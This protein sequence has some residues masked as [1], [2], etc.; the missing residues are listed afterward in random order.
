MRRR[1]AT[2]AGEIARSWPSLTDHSVDHLDAL[3]EV[4]DLLVAPSDLT[5][6]EVFLLG[7]AF[8]THDLANGAAA[9]PDGSATLRGDPR[10]QDYV[11][12]ALHRHLGREPDASER[13]TPPDKVLQEVTATL[14]R[15]RH[16]EKAAQLPL[17]PWKLREGEYFLID[18][19]ELRSW[20]G[21]IIGQIARS[22][23]RSIRNVAQDLAGPSRSAP[24]NLPRGWTYDPL[25]IAA[26]LRVADAA[27]VDDRR[28]RPFPMAIRRPEG[29]SIPHWEFQSRTHGPTVDG[30]QLLVYSASPAF[31]PD[32]A[33]A[34]WLAWETLQMVDGEVRQTNAMLADLNRPQLAARGVYGAEDPERFRARFPAEGWVPVNVRIRSSDIV[35]LAEKLGGR[36][37]YGDHPAVP[38][39]ELI[40]NASDAIRARR[41]VRVND[42]EWRG[43]ITV[44]IGEDERGHW[45]EVQDNGLGMF[46]HVLTG[47]LLDFGTSYWASTTMIEDYPGLRASAFKATGRY[48]IG[49]FSV[50]MWSSRFGSRHALAAR[51]TGPGYWSFPL[52]SVLDRLYTTGAAQS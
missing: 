25:R 39:R 35:S 11:L 42:E 14:L 47:P 23:G 3:W 33:E 1:A 46:D 26:I 8:L 34:W 22:H 7:G 18:D 28:A 51:D 37:L 19:T 41:F 29:D 6:L 27:Q 12:H 50:F 36:H 49:F 5:P 43:R 44:R 31:T 10:W 13:V 38:L 15:I 20:L 48:G 30:Q 52:E 16:S 4:A 45:L 9:Y 2:I 24:S 32:V 17:E 40:Q 21:P